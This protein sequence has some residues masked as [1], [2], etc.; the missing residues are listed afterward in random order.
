MI[1]MTIEEQAVEMIRFAGKLAAAWLEADPLFLAAEATGLGRAD[2]IIEIAV[3]DSSG[4]VQFETLVKPTIPF[5]GAKKLVMTPKWP[6]VLRQ[7]AQILANRSIII[8]H[9]E[10]TAR[11]ADQ[12]NEA[13][14]GGELTDPLNLKLW[15]QHSVE[16]LAGYAFGCPGDRISLS[17]ATAIAG[18]KCGSGAAATA[19]ATAKLVL[20]VAAF[21]QILEVERAP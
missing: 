8:Y 7:L 16:A 2:Q 9:L 12:T 17:E 5:S 20:A 4:Q 21:G 1:G 13:W 19:K 18:I 11:L 14:W 6:V 3:C 10:R 15:Q